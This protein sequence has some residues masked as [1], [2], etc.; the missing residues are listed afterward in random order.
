MTEQE[1]LACTDPRPMLEFLRGKVSDRKLRLF[2][3]ACCRSLHGPWPSP[4]AYNE[5]LEWAELFADGQANAEDLARIGEDV[6]GYVDDY[7]PDWWM[8]IARGIACAVHLPSADPFGI[9]QATLQVLRYDRFPGEDSA[10]EE[11]QAFTYQASLLRDLIGPAL[12]RP[13]WAL[14]SLSVNPAWLTPAAG[15]LAQGIYDTRAFDRLPILA[16][17]LEEAG[18]T[19]AAILAHCQG[20]GEHVRGCWVLDLV[21]GK[22]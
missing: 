17:A 4:P 18:C 19:N 12:F 15:A 7:A 13:R 2:A 1:W 9:R 11:R 10:A 3:V 5:F 16:D 8:G 14:A 22:S 21:L 20:L 6:T